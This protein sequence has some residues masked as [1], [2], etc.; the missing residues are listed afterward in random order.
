MRALKKSRILK[1]CLRHLHHQRN[2][3]SHRG[4]ANI[5]VTMT[6]TI[7]ILGSSMAGLGVAHRLL[8]YTVP[9]EKDLKVIIVSK[10]KLPFFFFFFF[11]SPHQSHFY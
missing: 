4:A 9:N 10:V 11:F 3:L 8:K 6:R 2:R 5:I 1:G 7:L